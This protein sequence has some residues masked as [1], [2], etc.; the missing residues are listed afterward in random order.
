MEVETL[1]GL[2]FLKRDS[3]ESITEGGCQ[4]CKQAAESR[5][6]YNCVGKQFGTFVDRT[7]LSDT[8]RDDDCEIRADGGT[9]SSGTERQ[10]LREDAQYIIERLESELEKKREA[11]AGA[12]NIEYT[13]GKLAGAKIVKNDLLTDGSLRK[14]RSL[15]TEADRNE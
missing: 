6:G 3:A 10:E 15:H 12:E 9:S 4:N 1:C 5:W 2:T 7:V 8:D 11:D 13:R 14:N